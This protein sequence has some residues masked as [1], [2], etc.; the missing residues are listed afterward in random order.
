[1]ERAFLDRFIGHLI[2][3]SSGMIKGCS[4]TIISHVTTP[5]AHQST[6][7]P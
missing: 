6:T 1:M 2:Q 3:M 4:P 5:R 7:G